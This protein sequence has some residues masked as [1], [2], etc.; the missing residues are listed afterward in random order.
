MKF[1]LLMSWKEYCKEHNTDSLYFTNDDKSVLVMVAE[2]TGDNLLKEDEEEGYVDYWN[3]E[4]YGNSGRGGGFLMR[5]T[6]IMEDN[7][8]IED[9]IKECNDFEENL[10]PI[11]SGEF[12][13]MDPEEGEELEDQFMEQEMAKI[14]AARQEEERE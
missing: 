12:Y 4:C 1:N 6:L 14:K 7:P 9:I 3:I 2:G 11:T 13:V 5:K 8:T 10:I